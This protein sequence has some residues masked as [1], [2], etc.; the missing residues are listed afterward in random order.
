V[1]PLATASPTQPRQGHHALPT[2]GR[3]ATSAGSRLS[4]E[5]A[6]ERDCRPLVETPMTAAHGLGRVGQC[7]S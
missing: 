5:L 7:P 3:T 2:P 6:R 1:A 4:P